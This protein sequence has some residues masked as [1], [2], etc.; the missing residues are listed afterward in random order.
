MELLCSY[1]QYRRRPCEE[2]A[3]RKEQG[4]MAAWRQQ[5]AHTLDLIQLV[6]QS[7]G[8]L[9]RMFKKEV[10]LRYALDS[11]RLDSTLFFIY[12]VPSYGI[13]RSTH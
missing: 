3:E 2:A 5:H 8:S 1:E 11:T 10:L 6:F 7:S 9:A 13:G 12:R 4:A